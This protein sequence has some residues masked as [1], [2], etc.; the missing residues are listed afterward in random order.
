MRL[1][2]KKPKLTEEERN[3]LDK[4]RTDKAIKRLPFMYFITIIFGIGSAVLVSG[5]IRIPERD[6]FN[7]TTLV[8][9]G[10]IAIIISWTVYIF[11]KKWNHDNKIQQKQITGLVS[12]IKKL[13]QHQQSVLE[14][15]KERVN[16]WKVEW[17][18]LILTELESVNRMYGILETWLVDY[19]KDPSDEQRSNLPVAAKRNVDIL[20]YHF[21]NIHK[22]VPRIEEHFDEPTL[23]AKLTNISTSAQFTIIFEVL[24]QEHYWESHSQS[25]FESIND[26]RRIINDMIDKIKNEIPNDE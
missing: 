3:D 16:R 1:F 23:G 20:K 19:W 22:Y 25:I 5:W 14:S 18:Y 21:Q 10:V 6:L 2:S 24:D 9:E 8:L 11:S 12:E 17:G 4:T 13:E 7:G 26:K 15:E